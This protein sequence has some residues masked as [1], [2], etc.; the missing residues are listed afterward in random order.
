MHGGN[1]RWCF[2]RAMLIAALSS[3]SARAGSV[4]WLGLDTQ[5]QLQATYALGIRTEKPNDGGINTAPA[6]K[7]P[8]PD[9]LKLP[10]SINYDDGDRNFR[11]FK[12]V[13][14]RLSLLGEILVQKGD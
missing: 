5:Y 10:E 11:R 12:P 1:M 2:A 9:Y 7:I 14:N 4:D 3:S 6:P 13:N 8:L